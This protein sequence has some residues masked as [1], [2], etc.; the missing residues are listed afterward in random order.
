MKNKLLLGAMTFLFCN[1]LNS[2]PTLGQSKLE[3]RLSFSGAFALYPM[4]VKWAE[5]FKRINPAVKIDISA[6]GAGKGMTDVLNNMVD[7]GMVSR[8]IY[9]EEVKKG[10]LGIAVTK[11]A[12]VAVM[13]ENN[14]LLKDIL[15]VGLKPEAAN[16]RITQKLESPCNRFEKLATVGAVGFSDL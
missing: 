11:D 8:E 9:P 6:G 2:I 13:S 15:A 16:D 7:I 4:A 10:A 14:P 12:V 5:E 3:G 1:F